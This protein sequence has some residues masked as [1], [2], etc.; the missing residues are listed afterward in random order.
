MSS[1]I[2]CCGVIADGTGTAGGARLRPKD[3][4]ASASD[5]AAHERTQLKKRRTIP[6]CLLSAANL[7]PRAHARPIFPGKRATGI[8][9][10][11]RQWLAGA[12]IG[13]V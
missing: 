10:S 13:C 7:R 8:F 5:L 2:G 11:G 9:R 3:W 1:T 4:N 6:G 12:V